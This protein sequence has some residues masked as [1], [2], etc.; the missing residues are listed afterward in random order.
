MAEKFENPQE[1]IEKDI[2]TKIEYAI[3]KGFDVLLTALSLDGKS[4]TSNVV[5]PDHFE[6]NV[7]WVTTEDGWGISIEVGRIKNVEL[8]DEPAEN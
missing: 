2:R 3:E 4:S 5:S 6:E 7:L 8:S 1:A